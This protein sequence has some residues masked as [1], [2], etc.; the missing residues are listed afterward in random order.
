M[1]ENVDASNFV[2]EAK[3]AWLQER[4]KFFETVKERRV[5]ERGDVQ[6]VEIQC[7]LP[8]GKVLVSDVSFVGSSVCLLSMV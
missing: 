4:E 8:D 2:G 1:S 6:G 5:A 7:K 3:P